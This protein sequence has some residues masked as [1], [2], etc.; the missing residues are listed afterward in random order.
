MQLELVK[1][2]IRERAVVSVHEYWSV[3]RLNWMEE[4]KISF[5]GISCYRHLTD[6]PF[7]RDRI[8]HY[9]VMVGHKLQNSNLN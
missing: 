5:R 2:D 9:I 4:N 7:N 1:P 8:I 3:K 6:G